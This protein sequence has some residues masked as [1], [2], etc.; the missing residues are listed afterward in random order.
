MVETK[1]F[2]GTIDD[3]LVQRIID[4]DRENMQAT[5]DQ[6]GVAFPVE[7]RRKS[8][9]SNPTLIIAFEGDDIVGYVEY[10]RSWN[11]PRYIYI[12]SFQIQKAYR[13][14]KLILELIDEFIDAVSGEDF[15]G[16][17][18]NVQKVNTPAVKMY[19]KLGFQLQENPRNEASWIATAG[20]ELLSESPIVSTIKK[21]KS[22]SSLARK[23]QV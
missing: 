13:R 8:F 18:T 11:D 12:G 22:R 7:N 14:T 16:F 6:A 17:E 21:W 23:P 3:S 2:N 10:L 20:P 15:L 19:R 5:L 1:V 4:F 9:Q